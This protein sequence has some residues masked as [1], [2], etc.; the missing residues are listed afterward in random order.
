[1][2]KR[3]I[4][5]ED[6]NELVSEFQYLRFTTSQNSFWFWPEN[7]IHN[8]V[9]YDDWGHHIIKGIACKNDFHPAADI[10]QVNEA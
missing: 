3:K 9:V 5:T 7:Y 1:M 2:R 6:L 8:S 10:A 4:Y